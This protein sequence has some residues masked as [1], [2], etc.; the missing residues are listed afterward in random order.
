MATDRTYDPDNIFARILRGELP[1]TKIYEDEHVLAFTNLYP[2]A[3]V[4][5][6]LVPKGA[7]TDLYDFSSRASEAELVS[8]MRAYAIVADKTGVSDSGCRFISNCGSDGGQEV[9]HLH[10][11]ILGGERLGALIGEKKTES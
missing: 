5:A 9:P 10:T 2:Q 1:S 8:Y 3:P 11:H 4:H 7:Y 6:L